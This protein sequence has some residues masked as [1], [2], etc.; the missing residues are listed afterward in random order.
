MENE[1]CRKTAKFLEGRLWHTLSLEEQM[2][3]T[4]L[5]EA[6]YLTYV[7]GFGHRQTEK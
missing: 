3:V 4:M 5:E 2:L 6:G 7:A 1:I